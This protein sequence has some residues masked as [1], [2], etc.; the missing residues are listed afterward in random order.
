MKTNIL[1]RAIMLVFLLFA[2]VSLCAADD[3]SGNWKATFEGRGPGGPGDG[4]PMNIVFSFKQE[5]TKL[6]G[7][8]TGGPGGE[9]MVISEGKI[10]GNKISFKA[11]PGDM[12]MLHE[13]TVE[14]DVIRL[15][16]VRPEGE[17]QGPGPMTMTLRKQP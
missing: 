11:G 7:S 4:G 6:T 5:G 15:K 3:I 8:I 17:D 2:A 12:Q 13:G 14:G 10:E 9:D 1:L 16:V